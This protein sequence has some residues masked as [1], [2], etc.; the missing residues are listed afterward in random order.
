[1]PKPSL[2]EP[3]NSL[4]SD[5]IDT[6]IAGHHEWR[7][8]LAYPES[9]SDM[10]GGIRAVLRMYEIKRRPIAAPIKEFI[11]EHDQGCQC[12]NCTK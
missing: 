6:F 5:L 2:K 11:S 7:P 9:Y 10:Q 4:E 1:M 12:G 8:D 3:Y